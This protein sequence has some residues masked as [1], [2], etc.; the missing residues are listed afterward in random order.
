MTASE[1]ERPLIGDNYR[2][3]D[4]IRLERPMPDQPELG[5]IINADCDL[6]N[7]KI[8]GVIAYLPIFKFSDYCEK[9]H[10]SDY[11]KQTAEQAKNKISTD[12][13]LEEK[14][15][16]DLIRWIKIDD[17]KKITE[18]IYPKDKK[19]KST[20]EE[21]IKN[22]E[23]IKIC[24][25]ENT[26]AI[27]IFQALC[28]KEANPSSLAKKQIEAAKK[29]MGDDHFFLS[30]IKGESSIG[31]VVRMRRIYTIESQRCFKSMSAR[32]ADKEDNKA[33][34]IRIA[35]LTPLYSFKVA[36]VFSQQYS[37]VG[38]PNEITALNSL[39]IEDLV[40]S[41]SRSS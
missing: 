12:L 16:I 31:F 13:N 23:K 1:T 2:Q 26:R 29:N 37:R 14:E 33:A 39:V 9:F 17:P 40:S 3:G 28:S 22:L 20:K 24:L 8:D 38:L 41:I 7:C 35:K 34:A 10:L 19:I 36:Q 21:I 15:I 30:E 32:Q 18:K 4:I 11:I 25:T 6:E 27:K 5:V